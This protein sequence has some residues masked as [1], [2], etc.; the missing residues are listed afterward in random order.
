MYRRVREERRRIIVHGLV[1][2]YGPQSVASTRLSSENVNL[3]ANYEPWSKMLCRRRN[4][5]D[6]LESQKH[7]K[8]DER[9]EL[10]DCRNQQ[11]EV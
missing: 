2:L 8:G 10:G 4:R 6:S 5:S 3:T 1:T 9:L 11:R 7:A